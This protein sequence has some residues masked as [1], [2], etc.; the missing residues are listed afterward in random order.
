MINLIR[1]M[2]GQYPVNRIG[3]YPTPLA[4]PA[5]M[6]WW[7]KLEVSP[8]GVYMVFTH[9]GGDQ[10]RVA[11]QIRSSENV[12]YLRMIKIRFS[13]LLAPEIDEEYVGDADILQCAVNMV[14]QGRRWFRQEGIDILSDRFVDNSH[15]FVEQ[16]R[17]IKREQR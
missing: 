7:E 17:N 16:I 12:T 4:E 5:P 3:S 2:L 1:R 6:D 13:G 10:W 15:R 9:P 11:F 14:E 8:E